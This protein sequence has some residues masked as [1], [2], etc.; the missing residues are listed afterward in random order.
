MR[1]RLEP[2]WQTHLMFADFDGS[3]REA[4]DHLVVR[5]PGSPSYYWGNFLLYQRLAVDADLPAW[6]AAFDEGIAQPEPACRHI[7]FGMQADALHFAMPSTFAAAGF[8]SFANTTLTL[9]PGQLRQPAAP[10]G[11]GFEIRALDLPR[12]AP[13]AVDVDMACN[14]DGYQP[15]A[16]RHFRESQLRRYGAMAAAGMG[17]WFGAFAQGQ[18]VA[19]L[20]LFGRAGVGRFQHVSTHP[21][22]RRRGL[23]RALVHAACRYGQGQRGWHTLVMCADPDDVAIGIYESLGFARQS[24]QWSLQRRAPHDLLPG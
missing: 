1:E 12:E 6:L 14:D 4:G 2:G 3:V 9:Q 19:G 16:Y 20:G 17:H 7:A 15:D 13:Q 11:S 22:W 24:M 5:S 23:C 10:L 8:E 21:A 18:M